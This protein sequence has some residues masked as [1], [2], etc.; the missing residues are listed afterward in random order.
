MIHF[1][2]IPPSVPRLPASRFPSNFVSISRICHACY[3][4]HPYHPP[5]FDLTNILWVQICSLLHPAVAY[6]PYGRAIAQT[7]S[8]WLPTAAARVRSQVSSCG[9][10]GEQSGTGAGLLRVL[11]FPLPILIPPTA[12]YSASIIRGWYNRPNSG[13]RTKW[14]QS[15]PTQGNQKKKKTTHLKVQ[16][17]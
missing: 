5:R 10:C 16:T 2:I 6:S 1:N 13:Q 8:R 9:I 14:T 4:S 15:H 3:M 12:P 11:L 7:V 17:K